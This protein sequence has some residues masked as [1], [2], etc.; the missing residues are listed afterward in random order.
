MKKQIAALLLSLVLI[1]NLLP[2]SVLAEELND[3]GQPP[4]EATGT[5]TSTE[6]GKGNLTEIPEPT[7]TDISAPV[8]TPQSPSEEVVLAIEYDEEYP[9]VPLRASSSIMLFAAPQTT[10]IGINISAFSG[11]TNTATGQQMCYHFIRDGAGNLENSAWC[12]Q[13]SATVVNGESYSLDGILNNQTLKDVLQIAYE[14]GYWSNTS[15]YPVYVAATQI[16]VWWAIGYSSASCSIS[17]ANTY[18][19]QL[20]NAALADAGCGGGD[21]YAYEC[22]T[23]SSHQRLATYYPYRA[24]TTQYG[25]IRIKKTSADPDLTDGNS[26]YSIQGAVYG[27]YGS[28]SNATNNRNC[29]DTLTTKS[30]GYTEYSIDLEAGYNYYVKEITAPT[31]YVLDTSVYTVY[32]DA[33][34]TTLLEVEDEPEIF[35]GNIQLKKTSANTAITSGNS[36]YSLQG[37]VYGIYS[38]KANAN[39]NKNRLGTLTTNASGVSEVSVDLEAGYNYYVKEITAPKGYAL[40][41]TVYTVSVTANKT[42]TLSVKDTPQSDPVGVLLK[43]VD[44]TTG[45]GET[46]S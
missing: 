28:R 31:G 32:V 14:W 4:I 44:A 22:T 19:S 38:S 25:D 6:E 46:C 20:Y 7:A 40:D 23:N 36:C 41:S 24:V 13:P 43:K 27:I 26:N 17:D 39:A 34:E 9:A 21:L 42:T 1:F 29:L 12:I 16:A 10:T 30:T 33:N 5:D 37:A 35:Y 3:T 18:A 15:Y 2:V 11:Y 45:K 8:D